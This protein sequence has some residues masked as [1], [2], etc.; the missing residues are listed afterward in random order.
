MEKILRVCKKCNFEAKSIDQLKLFVK[1]KKKIKFYNTKATC[2]KC[3][4]EVARQKRAGTYEY[5]DKSLKCKD[6]GI[7]PKNDVDVEKWFVKDKSMKSGYANLC[8]SCNLSRVQ[9]HQK[10]KPEMFKKR[11]KRYNIS[12]H[13]ISESKYFAILKAQNESCAICQKHQSLFKRGLYIDHDH[14]CCPSPNS[15]GKCVRGLLCASCNFLIGCANDDIKNLNRA[16]I[17]LN[18]GVQN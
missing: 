13:G 4:A 10:D 12:K 11:L 7:K 15:C 3:N 18:K 14:S 6:C 17:Y 16:I 1:D 5:P 9:K 2:K 8:K